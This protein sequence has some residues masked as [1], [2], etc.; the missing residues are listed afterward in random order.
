MAKPKVSIIIR[1]RNEERWIGPC[2]TSVYEQVFQD[3]EVV[4]VD[5]LSTD[6][7]LIK[8]KQFPVKLVTIDK[9][10][11]GAALNAGIS[12]SCGE[13]I[14]I[15]SGHCIPAGKNWLGQL[16]GN[17]E[18]HRIAGAYGRQLPMSF[19]SPQT[20]RDLMISFGLDRIEHVKDSFFHN[21][22]SAIR[23]DVWE[24]VPF[25]KE[26][27]NIEDRI[28]AGKVLQLGYR[29]VYDPEAAVYHYHGIHHDNDG[30]R[31]Q[32]TLKVI[33]KNNLDHS[34]KADGFNRNMNKVICL[35]PHNG[36]ILKHNGRALLEF[37]IRQALANDFIH[38]TI[39]LTDNQEAAILSQK[40]GAEVPILR[41]MEHSKDYFDLSMVYAHYLGELEQHGIFADLIVSMEPEYVWR[42]P[43]LI[44]NLLNILLR[45][46]F[47]SVVPVIREF[48]LAWLEKDETLVRADAGNLP[49]P[50]KSPLYISAKGLG[51]VTHS[52]FI[53]SGDMVGDHCGILPIDNKYASVRITS[54]D[55]VES[56]GQFLNKIEKD[57]P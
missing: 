51:F 46:G 23:R 40:C 57:I 16:A 45:D 43:D 54:K 31:L 19:S 13:F 53:R 14:V 2:L 10:L 50:L 17:L 27:T 20:K 33:R 52:E 36:P 56:W 26:V 1:T 15:L 48:G 44:S 35:I 21:A 42:P 47:D 32:N 25:N 12:S 22:N 38:K 9:Y 49:R 39:V 24:K 11:P 37:T 29:T 18:D 55:D 30:T 34:W 4:V 41:Q 7:T 3:F 5:N 8:L 6:G 28:W